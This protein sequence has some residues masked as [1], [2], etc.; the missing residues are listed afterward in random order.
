MTYQVKSAE[1]QSMFGSIARR[2]D[3]TNSVLSMG[4][5]RLWK[6]M[7][8]ARVPRDGKVLDLCTGTGDL[9][10]LLAERCKEVV[11][12]DFCEPMLDIARERYPKIKLVQCDALNLP[13]ENDSFDAVTVAFGVRNL[14]SLDKGLRE[15]NRVLKPGGTLVVLEFGQ[16]TFPVWRQIYQLYSRFIMPTIGGLLTGNRAAYEYLPQT[17]AKFPCAGDFAH[18]MEEAGFSRTRYLSLTGGIAYI[19]DG[20]KG[21]EA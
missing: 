15:M 17:A 16:P 9:L 8:S 19:Y 18:R 21:A 11:G 3:I 12:G 20:K 7:V 14:E 1:V 6:K 13:F 5:H 10:P 4:V 2:Y